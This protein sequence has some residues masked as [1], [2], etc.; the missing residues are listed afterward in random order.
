VTI[1]QTVGLVGMTGLATA[2]HLHFEVLVGG[3]QRDPRKALASTGGEPLPSA[4]RPAFTHLRDDY[5]A[6]LQR[7]TTQVADSN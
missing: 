3:V 5:L 7:A 4:E 1:G 2:P 6:L